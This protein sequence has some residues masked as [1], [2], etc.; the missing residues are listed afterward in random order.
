MKT[1]AV[2]LADIAR[3]LGVSSNAV[4]LALRGKE[5]VSE[6]L[7]ERIVKKAREMNY[8]APEA[9]RSCILALIPHRFSGADDAMYHSSFYHHVCFRMEA[10]AA[11]RDCQLI[12]S[13]VSPADEETLR[14]PPLLSTVPCTGIITVGNLSSGYCRMIRS[15]GLPYVMADQYYD[16]VPA[17]SVVTAN[18][19]GAYLLTNHLIERGHTNIQF[20]GMARRTSS[21]ED[22]WIGYKRAMLRHGLRPLDNRLLHAQSVDTDDSVLIP[23]ALDELDSLPTAFVCGHDNT[24]HTLI[25][26]LAA[27]G[28]RCPEDFS[29]VGFDDIQT[30]DVQALSLTT[31]STPKKAIAETAVR[32][33]L[34]GASEETMR[35]QLYGD[36]VYRNSVKD[37][38]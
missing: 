16:D 27:R 33:V 19:S 9:S 3:E 10:Y 25:R 34:E 20:F 8:S 6:A 17:S 5:G 35:I 1:K 4:S 15:Q 2:T 26:A 30:P 21:L 13:S 36:V 11:S 37:L 29:V 18:T 12:I 32:L 31:Y 23:Q 14:V 7:R 24:A 38:R 22:R 28:L